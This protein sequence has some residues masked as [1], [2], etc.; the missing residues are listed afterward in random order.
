MFTKQTNFSQRTIFK[1]IILFKIFFTWKDQDFYFIYCLIDIN[2]HFTFKTYLKISLKALNIYQ[3]ANYKI[4][5]LYLLISLQ[6]ESKRDEKVDVELMHIN[7][8][9]N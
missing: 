8:C 2:A 4:L 6:K 7:T 3:N 5:L 9:N 1:K